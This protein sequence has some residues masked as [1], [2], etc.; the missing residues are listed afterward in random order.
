[1][2]LRP[3]ADGRDGAGSAGKKPPLHGQERLFVYLKEVYLSVRVSFFLME[4]MLSFW[5]LLRSL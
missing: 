2:R 5:T 1:M 3:G 4:S